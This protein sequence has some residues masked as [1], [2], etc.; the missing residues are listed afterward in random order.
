[1]ANEKSNKA[2]S[3][4]ITG[5]NPA[6]S[7]SFNG[8][9][10]NSVQGNGASRPSVVPLNYVDKDSLQRA[11]MSFVKGGGLFLPTN[12][13][14]EMNEELFLLVTLPGSNKALPVPGTVVWQSPSSAAD[15]RKPGVGI[16]FK[17]R[18]GFSLRNTIE[19]ILGAQIGDSELTYT[20]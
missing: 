8:K 6:A 7:R 4:K 13:E 3:G 18:E 10:K 5:N 16:E 20:M 12:L 2:A 17:G 19:G 9:N 1:M 15:G 14:Y 11:Y